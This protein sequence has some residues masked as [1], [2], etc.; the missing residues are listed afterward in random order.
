M[1]GCWWW[2][3]RKRFLKNDELADR[4]ILWAS[5]CSSPHTRVTSKKSFSSRNFW[6]EFFRLLSKSFHLRQNFSPLPAS[7]IFLF[8]HFHWHINALIAS[9][10]LVFC[11]LGW[12]QMQRM[13][14]ADFISTSHTQPGQGSA[15]KRPGPARLTAE[16]RV[17]SPHS[18]SVPRMPAAAKMVASPGSGPM[19]W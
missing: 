8:S 7:S 6:N 17:C 16:C 19:E 3:R 4:I 13:V 2:L 1:S 5:I 15:W 11:V 10:I 12:Q 14:Q 18:H 9:L